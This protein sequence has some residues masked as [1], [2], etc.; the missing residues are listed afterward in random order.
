MKFTAD[1]SGSVTGVRFYKSGANMGIHTGTLWS[2]SGTLLATATFANESDF[3]WQQ[4]TFSAPVAVTPGTTYVV[5]Y[6]TTV[7]H[8]AA[9]SPG[10]TTALD[11]G[12]LHGLASGSSGGNGVYAYGPSAFPTSTFGAS[13]Y[14]VDVTFQPS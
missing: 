13:N 10:F 11:V 5:S 4:V 12:P 2:S 14:W 9:T 1:V 6:H 7:G 8:Y 3:G